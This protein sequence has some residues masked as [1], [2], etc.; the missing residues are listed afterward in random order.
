[1]QE[2]T[3]AIYN[4]KY[5]ETQTEV[6]EAACAD[7]V[8]QAKEMAENIKKELIEAIKEKDRYANNLLSVA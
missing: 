7:R 8:K 1:M 3:D 6:E 4:A 5:A 2:C